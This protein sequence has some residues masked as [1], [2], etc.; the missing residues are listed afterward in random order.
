MPQF[1]NGTILKVENRKGEYNG[2]P[3]EKTVLHILYDDNT[4]EQLQTKEEEL[5]KIIGNRDIKEL[6]GKKYSISGYQQYPNNKLRTLLM[7]AKYE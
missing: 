3:W 7:L 5:K 4:V 1:T 6:E 2:N